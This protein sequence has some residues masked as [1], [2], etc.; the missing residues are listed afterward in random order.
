VLQ[1]VAERCKAVQDVVERCS[2]L[3]YI[4]L[5]CLV[6][7]CIVLQCLVLHRVAVPCPTSTHEGR[8]QD[9]DVNLSI[10]L[11]LDLTPWIAVYSHIQMF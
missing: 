5:Q 11:A 8:E 9:L 3:F 7:F 2:V 6:L 4:V 10:P 1:C